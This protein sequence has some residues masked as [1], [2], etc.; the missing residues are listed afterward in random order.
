MAIMNRRG[1]NRKG[2]YGSASEKSY[3]EMKE[4]SESR[5]RKR[6]AALEATKKKVTP[7][8]TNA[9]L[10]QIASRDNKR[11]LTKTQ[12]RN[13]DLTGTR[14]RDAGVKMS[15]SIDASVLSNKKKPT[16][17]KQAGVG[18]IDGPRK[19]KTQNKSI[20]K[21]PQRMS[22]KKSTPKATTTATKRKAGVGTIDGPR[23]TTA[24]K[25]TILKQPQR[26]STK[27]STSTVLSRLVDKITSR[28]KKKKVST[29]RNKKRSSY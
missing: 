23:Q 6:K 29:G 16:P 12:S 27:K 10:K 5:K 13:I 4:A 3:Y 7:R 11:G 25:R 17:K 24:K 2:R 22:T 9:E 19:P 15:Q 1:D 18:T 26:T 14:K 21:Q 28:K 20:L 8:K